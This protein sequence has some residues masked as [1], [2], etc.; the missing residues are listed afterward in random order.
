M[1]RGDFPNK[2]LFYFAIFMSQDMPLSNYSVPGNFRMGLLTG[3]GCSFGGLADYFQVPL[4]GTPQHSVVLVVI[5]G[6]A[7]NKHIYRLGCVEHIPLKSSV[8]LF[9]RHG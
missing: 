9:M 6:L 1:K 7:A 8:G 5:E 4:H 2:L 3:L